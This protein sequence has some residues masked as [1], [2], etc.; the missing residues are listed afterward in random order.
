MKEGRVV[1]I[2]GGIGSLLVGRFLSNGD[3]GGL[4]GRAVIVL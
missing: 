4:R 2:T 3:T 1:V